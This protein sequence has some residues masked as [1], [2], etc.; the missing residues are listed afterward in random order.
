MVDKETSLES[1]FML[2]LSGTGL[3]VILSM[4]FAGDFQFRTY[5]S[6]RQTAMPVLEEEYMLEDEE[7]FMLEDAEELMYEDG[8]NE[9]L[10]VEE[11]SDLE[12]ELDTSVNPSVMIEQ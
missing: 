11:E 12:L 7:E 4:F 10:M 6:S 3:V 5:A 8:G 9:D 1:F 2:L